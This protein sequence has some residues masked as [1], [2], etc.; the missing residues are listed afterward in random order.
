[1]AVDSVAQSAYEP[2]FLPALND[3]ERRGLMSGGVVRS[4]SAGGALFHEN[5]LADRVLV[6]QEGFVKLSCFSDDGR[7]VVLAIRGP[8]DVLGELAALDGGTR[9]ATAVALEAVQALAVPTTYFNDFL[10]R[11]PRVFRL[12]L[13]ILAQRLRDADRLRL[14]FASKETMGR[15]ASRIV[16]LSERFGSASEGSIRIDFPLT[17]EEL[18][19]WTACSRDSV[20]KALQS[21]R[22]LGWI[23][24]GRRRIQVIDLEAVRR[25]AA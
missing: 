2:R 11:N 7:E 25:R 22:D 6:L 10:D 15:V 8:G 24:T 3:D 18:A 4:F 23:E 1:M 12:L 20:V 17:Q 16:E 21:M 14:E 19:G 9:S 13:V 5:Q